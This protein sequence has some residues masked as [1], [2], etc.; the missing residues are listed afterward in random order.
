MTEKKRKA[1]EFI[2]NHVALVLVFS[3]AA[4]AGA[5]LSLKTLYGDFFEVPDTT[6]YNGHICD[7]R[8][9]SDECFGKNGQFA[10]FL[11]ANASTGIPIKLNLRIRFLGGQQHGESDT[12]Y[13]KIEAVPCE[14][15]YIKKLP[16]WMGG[17]EVPTRSVFFFNDEA[18]AEHHN[19]ICGRVLALVLPELEFPKTSLNQVGD[20][21][22]YLVVGKFLVTQD[23][24]GTMMARWDLVKINN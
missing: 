4:I 3:I 5:F 6:F 18:D 12:D 7:S 14:D 21:Y 8:L 9:L 19:G 2:Q 16:D 15:G 20:Q 13:K 10:N 23:I 11:L 1:I 17:K 22:E 24:T